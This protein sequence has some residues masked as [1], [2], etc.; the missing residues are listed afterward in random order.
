MISI[1]RAI[2]YGPGPRERLD[3]YRP[4]VPGPVIVYLYGGSW[5]SGR[6]EIY[7]FLGASLARRGFLTIIPDYRVYP[8]VRFPAFPE[9]AGRILRFVRERAAGWGGDPNRI[10]LIGHSAGA[11]SAALVA[12]ETLRYGAPPLAGVV[13]IAGPMS[14]NPLE[15][16]NVR[17]VFEGYSPI[18]DARPI[19]RVHGRAPPLL[20]LHGRADKTVDAHNSEHLAAAIAAAGGNAE[21]K[22][23][24]GLGHVGIIAS[25]AWPLRWRAPVLTDIVRFLARPAGEAVHGSIVRGEAPLHG[26]R[27]NPA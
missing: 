21:L 10:F 27:S 23:Y 26:L 15:H 17:A 19:K 3:L 2:A 1:E 20:L 24:P 25:I 16:D 22:L 18:D 11:H 9:D 7:R 5:Q 4:G 13:A 12:F 14:F 6:R 8:E